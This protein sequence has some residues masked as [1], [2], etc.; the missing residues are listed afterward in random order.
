VIRG[1]LRHDDVRSARIIGNLDT[2]VRAS[3]EGMLGLGATPVHVSD[4]ITGYGVARSIEP[5]Y[6]RR[7][8][9]L[10]G[11]R[12]LLEGFGNVGASCGVYLARAG[13]RIVGVSDARSAMA[14]PGGLDAAEIEDLMRRRTDRLI[15]PSDRLHA[16][17][18]HDRLLD[19]PADDFVAAAVS[20]SLT[21][22]RLDRLAASGVSVIAGGAKQPFRELRIGSGRMAQRADRRFAVLA[23]ILANCGMARTFSFLMEE[24]AAPDS[25]AIFAAVDRAIDGNA[26]RGPRPQRR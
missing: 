11:V 17:A 21:E 26:G 1:H 15:P 3:V 2:G 4:M 6:L 8:R 13:A 9:S 22:S 25:A 14:A 16:E 24:A 23:D 12:V 20:G 10:E 7:G 18:D 19:I 5:F